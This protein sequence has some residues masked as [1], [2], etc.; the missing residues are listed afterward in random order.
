MDQLLRNLV[1]S[2]GDGDVDDEARRAINL[3]TVQ[4]SESAT[5]TIKRP[6]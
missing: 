6:N 2:D 3:E 1:L 5:N 4:Q